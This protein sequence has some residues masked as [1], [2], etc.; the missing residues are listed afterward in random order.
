MVYHQK[1]SPAQN[2]IKY[3]RLVAEMLAV[4]DIRQTDLVLE[5]GP[6]KGII[7]EQLCKRA[8]R[9]IG[10]EKDKELVER[11]RTKFAEQRNVEIIEGD[12]LEYRLLEEEYKVFANIP[13]SITA[14][15]MNKFLKSTTMPKEL[16]LI[17]QLEVAEK[18]TGSAKQTMSSVLTK[19]W[20]EIEIVGD[21]DRTS[22]LF[23]PQVKIVLVKFTK[24]AAP[25]VRD[26]LKKEFRDF[27]I[28]G[29]NQWKE[30][31]IEAYKDVFSF[32]QL[33]TLKKIH[34]VEGLKPGQVSFDTWLHLF[35]NYYKIANERQKGVVSAW[36]RKMN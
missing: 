2:F 28:F 4:S 10:V 14:E 6:G 16:Y 25:L 11:L 35:K 36:I 31:W 23:K 20:Y 33:D 15:I 18:F 17:M 13:F 19:P 21:I 22:F 5:I 30:T 29:F 9:V 32:K 7:T 26:D 8:R 1:D 24:R 27:V 3:P 34:K 12:F